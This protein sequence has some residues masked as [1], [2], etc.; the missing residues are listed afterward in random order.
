MIYTELTPGLV[1]HFWKYMSETFDSKSVTK[2]DSNFMKMVGSSLDL[3][4]IQDKEKFMSKYTTTIGKT[5]YVSF[6]IG[7]TTNKNILADQISTCVHEHQHVIQYKKDGFKFMFEYLFEHEQRA[8]LEAVAY[9]TNLEMYYW[10][11]GK[12]LDIDKLAIKL[13]D[14]DCDN[15][16]VSVMKVILNANALVIKRGGIVN[17]ASKKAIAWLNTYAKDVKLS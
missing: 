15:I 1:K 4:K 7:G 17:E 14:Y 3:M 9:S 5:I 16:D 8:K 11:T 2:K 12:M 13:L 6:D 10:Y